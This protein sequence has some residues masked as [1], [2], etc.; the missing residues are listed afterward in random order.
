MI[1]IISFPPISTI[2]DNPNRKIGK[3]ESGKMGNLEVPN[4]LRKNNF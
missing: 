3:W 4:N 2:Q 1:I